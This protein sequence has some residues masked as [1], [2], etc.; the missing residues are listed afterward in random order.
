MPRVEGECQ[1]GRVYLSAQAFDQVRNKTPFAFDDLG[2]KSLKNIDRPVRI[3]A[4]RTLAGAAECS[5][6]VEPGKPLPLSEEPPIAVLPFQ[7]MSGEAEL[8]YF[9][10]GMVED[11]ITELSRFR[12]LIFAF[13]SCL[14]RECLTLAR[15]N[16]ISFLEP[17]CEMRHVEKSPV[18][19]NF[20]DHS[21]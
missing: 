17:P 4:A 19:S 11:I 14:F 3:C 15:Q 8:E 16:S 5:V 20:A 2:E 13:P 21:M 6:A 9:A 10:D 18:V 12:D 1:P 7:N